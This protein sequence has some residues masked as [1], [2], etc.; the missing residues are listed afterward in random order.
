MNTFGSLVRA[1]FLSD[2]IG[3]LFS[4]W[5]IEISFAGSVS[6]EMRFFLRAKHHLRHALR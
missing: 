3:F 1:Q 2:I 6:F 4:R 5:F